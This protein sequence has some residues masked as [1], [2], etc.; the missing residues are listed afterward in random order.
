MRPLLP[1]QIPAVEYAR[2]LDSVLLYME[3]RLGKCTV[4]I[5]WALSKPGVRRVLVVAPKSAIPGWQDELEVDGQIA[6]D[7]ADRKRWRQNLLDADTK[8]SDRTLFCVTN[9]QALFMPAKVVKGD[10]F[11][12]GHGPVPTELAEMPWQ[13]VIWDE[14]RMLAN[15]KSQ[16]TKIANQLFGKLRYKAALSG[17]Y[18]PEGPLDIFGPAQWCQGQFM[19]HINFWSWRNDNFSPV[20]YDFN[21]KPGALGRVNRA[22][23]NA[24][25]ILSR[26]DA[27][28]GEV[29]AFERRVCELPPEIRT[30]Y[31]HAERYF[32][33][34]EFSVSGSSDDLERVC[35]DPQLDVDASEWASVRRTHQVSAVVD[36]NVA[37][38]VADTK[39]AAVTFSWL[40]QIA[41]GRMRLAEHLWHDEKLKLLD[42]AALDGD[43]QREPLVVSFAFNRELFAAHERLQKE[44]SCAMLWGGMSVAERGEVIRKFRAGQVRVVLKQSRVHF[45]MDLSR[46]DTMI[47]YS[48]P[49]AYQDISQDMDRI[50]SPTKRRPLLYIDLLCADTVDEDIWRA[51]QMKGIVARNFMSKVRTNYER[52]ISR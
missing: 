28:L 27:G 16:T 36:D 43:Y 49:C 17:E 9:S 25:F 12:E 19:G 34:P 10:R 47:R 23:H 40:S 46:A 6:V 32:E 21:P 15:P 33:I 31:K 52:R 22:I 44:A 26:K 13:A 42:D 5:R 41:G 38:V 51:I 30:A 48:R 2:K 18:A 50:V 37:N 35:T 29:R 39:N 24:A 4:A 11:N 20:G 1:H 7:V 45:G 8:F 14:S 3:K